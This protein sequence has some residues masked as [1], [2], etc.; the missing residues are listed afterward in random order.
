[1]GRND[2]ANLR[3][4]MVDK[5]V[6]KRGI[7]D[8]LVIESLLKVPRHLFVPSYLQSYAYDDTPLPIEEGQTISQPFIVALMTQ[9]A[10]L[11]KQSHVLEIGTGSGYSTAILSRIVSHVY[12]VE[13]LLSLAK[14]ASDRFSDLKYDNI[15]IKVGDG[16]LGWP[17]KGPFDA[18]IVTAGAP[19][20]PDALLNQLNVLG[21]LIIPVGSNWIQELRCYTKLEDHSFKQE[22]IEW[23]RFVPLIGEQGWKDSSSLSVVKS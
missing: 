17:E 12:T 6:K 15:Q 19:V 1:M 11:N 4:K 20:V 9:L 23:V 7:Q 22:S 2:E 18:I 14:E 16:T 10:H 5:Q 3:Q 21:R 8:E 13:R